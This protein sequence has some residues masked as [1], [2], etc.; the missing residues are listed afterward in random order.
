MTSAK[1]ACKQGSHGMH[2]LRISDLPPSAP[3]DARKQAARNDIARLAQALKNVLTTALATR[4]TMSHHNQSHALEHLDLTDVKSRH[5][6]PPQHMTRTES[7]KGW[8]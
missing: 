7:S 2:I 8:R 3:G 1:R 6:A 4:E 5:I